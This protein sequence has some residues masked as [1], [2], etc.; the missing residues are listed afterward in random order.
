M[1]AKK[2]GLL[3]SLFFSSTNLLHYAIF[4]KKSYYLIISVFMLV[5]KERAYALFF[6]Y[7]LFNSLICPCF[8]TV[9]NGYVSAGC[10]ERI[11]LNLILNPIALAVFPIV[12]LLII[13]SR[14]EDSS[15]C[16]FAVNECFAIPPFSGIRPSIMLTP[17]CN[18][19]ITGRQAAECNAWCSVRVIQNDC[20]NCYF[21]SVSS[22]SQLRL[23]PACPFS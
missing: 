21:L 5:I 15:L 6:I 19:I 12:Q 10:R 4:Q 18:L 1:Q 20:L 2:R 8:A 13:I 3:P 17:P 23:K 16:F 22:I 9:C 7:N 14:S 11:W